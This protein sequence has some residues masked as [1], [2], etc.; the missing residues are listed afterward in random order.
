MAQKF[1]TNNGK[2]NPKLRELNEHNRKFWEQR[3]AIEQ[4]LLLNPETA[5]YVVQN[6]EA[7]T[8]RFLHLREVEKRAMA[9]VGKLQKIYSGPSRRR[10]QKDKAAFIKWVKLKKRTISNIQNL[11]A[12]PGFEWS[13]YKNE[14]LKQWHKEAMPGIRLKPGRPRNRG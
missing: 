10:D 5:S 7:D 1:K 6:L 9:N 4:R 12:Q 2:V 11:R 8:Q 14:T 3:N 13:E